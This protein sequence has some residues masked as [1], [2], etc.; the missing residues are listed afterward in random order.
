[1]RYISKRTSPGLAAYRLLHLF[2]DSGDSDDLGIQDNSK[3]KSSGSNHRK[4]QD[5]IVMQRFHVSD[6]AIR[7]DSRYYLET[8][9]GFDQRSRPQNVP[10]RTISKEM[11]LELDSFHGFVK[12][13]TCSTKR[14]RKGNSKSKAGGNSGLSQGDF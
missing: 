13:Q 7:R 4:A 9:L 12:A 1:M 10:R 3:S 11:E 8:A 5:M 2:S 14:D 6:Q